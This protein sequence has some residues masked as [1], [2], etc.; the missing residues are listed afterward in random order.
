[1]NEAGTT[2]SQRGSARRIAKDTGETS[3]AVRRRIQRGEKEVAQ[4]V[5]PKKN[6]QKAITM[7]T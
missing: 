6:A 3:G 4:P 1:M 5:P 7:K 2:K